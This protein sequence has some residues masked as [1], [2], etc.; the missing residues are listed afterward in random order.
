M[1]I[2]VCF[3]LL[4]PLLPLGKGGYVFGWLCFWLVCLFVCGQY[5]SK[6]YEWI[7]MKF[8]GGVLGSTMKNRLKFGGD[9]GIL[10]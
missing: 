5:Y 4:G 3:K 10:R 7:G 1:F 2:K 8:Y 9:L 6:C